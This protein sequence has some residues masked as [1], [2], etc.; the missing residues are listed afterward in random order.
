[1]L[2]S[3]LPLDLRLR[4]LLLMQIPASDSVSPDLQPVKTPGN[5][6][7]S[8]PGCLHLDVGAEDRAYLGKTPSKGS[9]SSLSEP[10][11][12]P[13]GPAPVANPL[14]TVESVVNAHVVSLD[15]TSPSPVN[16][17][18]R[19]TAK[20][21]KK[22]PFCYR[23]QRRGHTYHNCTSQ[24]EQDFCE[25]CGRQHVKTDNC[26]CRGRLPETHRRP[27]EEP[28]KL[29]PIRSR[30]ASTASST[31]STFRLS[32]RSS[33]G[34]SHASSIQ[35]LDRPSTSRSYQP[36]PPLPYER[37][38]PPPSVQSDQPSYGAS[39]QTSEPSM[40]FYGPGS[41][42]VPTEEELRWLELQRY[43]RQR[44]YLSL[45]PPP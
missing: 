1:M 10:E 34:E 43:E 28:V 24:R 41:T 38:S 19:R 6:A 22:V 21:A 13:Y 29:A 16:Q 35:P 36:Y 15:K 2:K 8:D 45:P 23:C 27:Q 42:F 26:P 3:R 25:R 37:R 39:R 4:P 32:G 12:S 30:L 5:L 11:P 31:F 33:Y 20:P 44:L 40:G 14:N 9:H 18:V 17:E 7:G